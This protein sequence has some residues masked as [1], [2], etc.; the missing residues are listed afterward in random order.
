MAELSASMPAAPVLHTFV[1]YLIAFGSR[2][3]ATSGVI[4]DRF[5]R[6]IVADKSMKFRDPRLNRSGEIRPEAVIRGA[7]SDVAV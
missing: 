1:Q 6:L 3:E 4:S 2:R 7:I 5:V